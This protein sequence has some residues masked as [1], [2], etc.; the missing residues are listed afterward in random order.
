VLLPDLTEDGAEFGQVYGFGEVEI[1]A[2][3][4]A[5]LD[6]FLFV[7]AGRSALTGVCL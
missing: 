3:L 7:E 1:E 5:A 2:G 4:F 6:V